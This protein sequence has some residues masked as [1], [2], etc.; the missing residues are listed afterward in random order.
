MSSDPDSKDPEVNL[1]VSRDDSFFSLSSP[2]SANS[3]YFTAEN[4]LDEAKKGSKEKTTD[5]DKEKSGS[6]SNGEDNDN[7]SSI[8]SSMTL[9]EAESIRS[10]SVSE[11]DYDMDNGSSSE[12][13]GVK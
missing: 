11:E 2:T 8:G 1:P 9:A 13:G 4:T 3:L 12:N 5:E 7:E 10:Y 6:L